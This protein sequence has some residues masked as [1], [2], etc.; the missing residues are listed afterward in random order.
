M[1]IAL[2]K[3][4]ARLFA[5]AAARMSFHDC[6]IS[7]NFQIFKSA[8]IFEISTFVMHVMLARSLARSREQARLTLWPMVARDLIITT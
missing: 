3:N 8:C 5:R 7:S 6:M 4:T 2:T 1:L